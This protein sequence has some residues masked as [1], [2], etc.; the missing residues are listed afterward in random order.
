LRKHWQLTDQ[1]TR[2]PDVVM[3]SRPLIAFP[4]HRDRDIVSVGWM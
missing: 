2:R 1:N 4:K 3:K